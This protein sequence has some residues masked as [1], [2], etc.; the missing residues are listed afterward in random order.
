MRACDNKQGLGILNLFIGLGNAQLPRKI[1][2]LHCVEVSQLNNYFLITVESQRE[3]SSS[4]SSNPLLCPPPPKSLSPLSHI[5]RPNM[6]H[7]RSSGE[8][9]GAGEGDGMF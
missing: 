8:V 9:K 6:T 7:F 3:R 1:D 5:R 4:C 2:F